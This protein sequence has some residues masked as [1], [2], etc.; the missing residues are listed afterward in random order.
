MISFNRFFS[1]APIRNTP[2]VMPSQNHQR[3]FELFVNVLDRL[4][5]ALELP[6]NEDSRDIVIH[7]FEFTYELA[8]KTMKKALEAE[9]VPAGP[10]RETLRFALENGLIADGSAWSEVHA[11]RNLTTHTYDEAI[12]KQVYEFVRDR[13]VDLFDEFSATMTKWQQR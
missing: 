6:P 8:W 7:R 13:A 3:T 4:H 2:A 10:P 12:A 11:S 5:A 1:I 9:D